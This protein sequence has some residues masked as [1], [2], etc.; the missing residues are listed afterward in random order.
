ME[1]TILLK[2]F[3]ID[4]KEF[5]TVKEIKKLC[6]EFNFDYTNLVRYF[7]RRGYLIRIF[8][9]IFNIR[10]PSDILEGY[11]KYTHH[12]L[13]A[14]GLKLKGIHNWYFG[15]HTALKLNNLTHEYF[16]IDEVVNDVISRPTPIKIDNHKFKFI[17]I[18][19]NLINLGIITN[20]II[21]Y[22]DSE[23]TILDFI[24]LWK[25]KGIPPK[26]ISFDISDW[27]SNIS[28]NKIEKYSEAYPNSVKKIVKEM[29]R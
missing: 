9:G 13:V 14:H 20:G 26:K 24:Y 8:N 4:E 16:T 17:K 27:V 29:F 3:K 1:S 19:K 10:Y 12:E 2:K 22:S 5:V 7:L 18:S 23:K 28:K 25:A 21:R 6:I 11:T 15:L